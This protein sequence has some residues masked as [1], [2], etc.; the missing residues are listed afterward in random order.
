MGS[1]GQARYAAITEAL[2]NQPGVSRSGLKGFGAG[3]LMVQ[4][5]LFAM[6]RHDDLLLKL[7]SARVA[8]LITCG[9][10][11]PF[12]A[13]KGRP[14]KEWVLATPA[15]AERWLA[16]AEEAMGFVAGG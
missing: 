12:D 14:M 9:D 4:G 11:K 6:L 10:G 16:L 5:R 8:A 7:P 13:G 15:A 1:E 3:G 2:A